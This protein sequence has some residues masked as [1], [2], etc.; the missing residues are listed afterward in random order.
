MDDGRSVRFL[1][2]L[3]MGLAARTVG[4]R[5]SEPSGYPP[6]GGKRSPRPSTGLQDRPA[7]ATGLVLSLFR[8]CSCDECVPT[9][10]T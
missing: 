3:Y 5:Q 7:A 10:A 8:E 9:L 2:K 6:G 4:I 1:R